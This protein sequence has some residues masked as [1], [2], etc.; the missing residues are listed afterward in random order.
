MSQQMLA[1]LRPHMER[2]KN[3]AWRRANCPTSLIPPPPYG[4]AATPPHRPGLLKPRCRNGG[5]RGSDDGV[6]GRDGQGSVTRLQNV[7]C[8]FR[9]QVHGLHRCNTCGMHTHNP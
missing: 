8:G 3:L 7:R 4:G 6:C 2:L 9:S 5:G 1:Q